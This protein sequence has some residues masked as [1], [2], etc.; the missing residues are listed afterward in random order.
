MLCCCDDLV[1]VLGAGSVVFFLVCF[2]SFLASFICTCFWNAGHSFALFA[3]CSPLQLTHVGL[4]VFFDES[5]LHSWF[6]LV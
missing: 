4:N 3:V 2:F 6:V 1:C 5:R